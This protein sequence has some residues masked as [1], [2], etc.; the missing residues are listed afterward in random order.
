MKFSLKPNTIICH[1]LPGA[2]LLAEVVALLL[3]LN[4]ISIN[5]IIDLTGPTTAVLGVL[6]LL[7][8][9][10]IGLIIDAVRN[11]LEPIWDK[12]DQTDKDGEWWDYFFE[13][14]ENFSRN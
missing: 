12:L 8:A 2:F 1:L 10:I 6:A 9:L 11:L 13:G 7:L 5:R 4:I 14:D 3:V